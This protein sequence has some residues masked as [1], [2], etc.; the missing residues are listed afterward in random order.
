MINR[1]QEHLRDRLRPLDMVVALLLF[2]CSFPGSLVSLPGTELR[3]SWW[4]GVLLS[5]VSCIA[6][7]WR[8]DHPRVIVAVTTACAVMMTVLGYLPTALLMA[9]LMVALYSLAVHT[10]RSATRVHGLTATALVVGVDLLVGFDDLSLDLRG[11]DGATDGLL[12]KGAGPVAYLLLSIVFGSAVRLRRA[13]LREATARAEHAERSREEEA[14]HRVAAER[15]RIA[16]ELHDVVAHHLVLANMQAGTAA[17]LMRTD[18]E[19]VTKILTDLSGTTS[20][21][22]R[23]LKATVGLL[24]QAGDPDVP[25]E[26]APGLARLPDLT[27][28]FQATGLT[29]TV[30]TEGRPRPLSPGVDLTAFRIV[31]EALTNVTKH[32]ATAAACVRLVYAHDR[33][34]VTIVNDHGAGADGPAPAAPERDGGFGLIGMRE[35]ALSVGGRLQAGPRPGGGFQVT[36][37]LPLQP[38]PPQEGRTP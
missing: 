24:R 20:S 27:G 32:A 34:T 19:Q 33:L 28:S 8:R 18:P 29:V 2:G 10:D 17:H 12:L 35:R 9:P 30:S 23:E 21:A 1:W 16:R 36:A 26:P 5:G 6:L 14:R 31:Q 15:M 7:L 37:D 3:V 13:Y 38:A 11:P 4:P 25:T 22:L